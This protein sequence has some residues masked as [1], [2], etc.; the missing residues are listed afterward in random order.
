MERADL[1]SLLYELAAQQSANPTRPEIQQ[2]NLTTGETGSIRLDGRNLT[3][4]RERLNELL[5]G[6][7]GGVY[8]PK[9]DPMVCPT[10]PFFLICPA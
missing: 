7:R 4:L 3:R 10:C 1:R 6:M 2:Q 9:P 5:A 8:P